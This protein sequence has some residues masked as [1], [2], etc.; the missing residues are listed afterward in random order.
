MASLRLLFLLLVMCHL[1]VFTMSG[2]TTEKHLQKMKEVVKTVADHLDDIREAVT[3]LL[4][5]I[6]A[7]GLAISAAVNLILLII[8]GKT[9]EDKVLKTVVD[10]FQ[11]LNFKLDRYHVEQRWDS[12]ASGAYHKPEMDIEVAWT[13]LFTLVGSLGESADEH[14]IQRHLDEFLTSYQKYEPATKILQMLLTAKKTTFIN[15]LGQMLAEHTTCNQ[16]SIREYAVFLATLFFKG[17]M[18]NQIYYHLKNISS[19]ARINEAAQIQYDF[20]TAM[21]QLQKYCTTHITAY[22]END[23]EGLI[24]QKTNREDLAKKIRSHLETKHNSFDWMVVA[25]KTKNSERV[26]KIR[27]KHTLTGFTVVKKGEIS[28]AVAQQSKGA[29][30]MAGKV[31]TAIQQ[32]FIKTPMCYEVEKTLR[33]CNKTVGEV[34][35][36]Q[37]Y[38]AVHAFHGNAHESHTDVSDVSSQNA[39]N[40]EEYNKEVDISS[41]QDYIHSGECWIFVIFSKTPIKGKYQVLIKSDEAIKNNPCSNMKCGSNNQGQCVSVGFPPLPMCECNHPYYGK[42][43]EKT[44]DDYKKSLSF[45]H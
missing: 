20:Q 27:N 42:N 37:T 10:E 36:S 13:S 38:T 4:G 14:T 11:N 22:V 40:Y 32:C 18:L 45:G 28:V 19:E 25:F 33:K 17:N 30:T 6:D 21:F 24:D 35:L 7:S 3:P 12:W 26:F 34:P 8:T 39:N 31:K 9:K 2:S 5:L 44:I 15:N 29:H 23:I 43:C 16:N 1:L 41:V